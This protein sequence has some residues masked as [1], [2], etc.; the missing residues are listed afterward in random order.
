MSVE[1]EDIGES[2]REFNCQSWRGRGVQML[3]KIN[4]ITVK[5]VLEGRVGYG[6]GQE[7]WPAVLGTVLISK[8]VFTCRY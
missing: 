8:G 4:E 3:I 1:L 6:W 2:L 5:N 7:V